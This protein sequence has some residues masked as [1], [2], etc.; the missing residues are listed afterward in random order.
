MFRHRAGTSLKAA[1]PSK[2]IPVL[3]MAAF[4]MLA[5]VGGPLATAGAEGGAATRAASARVNFRV[6]IPPVLRLRTNHHPQQLVITARDAAAG[7]VE[8]ASGMELEVHCN[9]RNG[10]A[11]QLAVTSPIVDAVEV[12]G[13]PVPVR[14]GALGGTVSFPRVPGDPNR[15]LLQL[16]FRVKLAPDARPGIYAWPVSVSFVSA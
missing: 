7:Y 12:S 10:F 6:V 8:V 2:P 5:G 4:L 13:L 1:P 3:L 9:L 14:F 11:M 16:G 15:K